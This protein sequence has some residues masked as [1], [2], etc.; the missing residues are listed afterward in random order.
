MNSSGILTLFVAMSV[1]WFQSPL[2]RTV[3]PWSTVSQEYDKNP[4]ILFRGDAMW[5]IEKVKKNLIWDD[6]TVWGVGFDFSA[7]IGFFN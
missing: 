3:I 5:L 4:I 2:L 7:P 6:L 1:D